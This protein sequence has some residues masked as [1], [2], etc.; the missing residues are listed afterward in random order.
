VEK[1][2]THWG[3]AGVIVG[4]PVQDKT[5]AIRMGTPGRVI[6][7]QAVLGGPSIFPLLLHMSGTPLPIKPLQWYIASSHSRLAQTLGILAT[8]RDLYHLTPATA[9][10]SDT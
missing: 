9:S 10:G 3:Q 5:R 8:P 2:K 4:C 7:D 1:G 6:T